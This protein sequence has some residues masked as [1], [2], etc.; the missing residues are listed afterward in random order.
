MNPD[1]VNALIGGALIGLAASGMMWSNGRIMGISGI[2][3]GLVT[4][5]SKD[6]F[7][8]ILF[9]VGVIV[10]SLLIPLIGFTVMET[11]FDRSLF[12]AIGG[13]LFVGVGTTI[14]SGCTSGHGVCGLSRFSGRSLAATLV[15]MALGIATVAI[16]EKVIGG[17]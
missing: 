9:V 17:L 4:D 15:F 13:G 1:F 3:G 8:R 10:G 11:P 16:I 12:A 2:L 7:W 5:Q 6:T 14:G